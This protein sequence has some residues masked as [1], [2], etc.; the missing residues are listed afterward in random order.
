[1]ATH[2]VTLGV[3]YKVTNVFKV[4]CFAVSLFTTTINV[5]TIKTQLGAN[6]TG[7]RTRPHK[8]RMWSFKKLKNTNA[9]NSLRRKVDGGTIWTSR[10]TSWEGKEQ[11]QGGSSWR[12]AEN[13]TPKELQAK[14]KRTAQTMPAAK[15]LRVASEKYEAKA[16]ENERKELYAN[17]TFLERRI[18]QIYMYISHKHSHTHT[19]ISFPFTSFF[20]VARPTQGQKNGARTTT[21][22]EVWR[23]WGKNDNFE[24]KSGPERSRESRERGREVHKTIGHSVSIRVEKLAGLS[25]CRGVP[26]SVW[27][28]ELCMNN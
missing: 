15:K 25:V 2:F 6:G 4:W 7:I 17:F 27:R 26:W 1:M 13:T 20:S 16:K 18:T 3:S 8:I 23:M 22:Y 10:T 24:V 14:R 9:L 28:L 5:A 19:Y 21:T 12:G 11:G